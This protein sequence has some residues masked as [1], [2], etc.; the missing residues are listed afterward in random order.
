MREELIDR[1]KL[2]TFGH[3]LRKHI[4]PSGELSEG[5]LCARLR[6]PNS[7]FMIII[8]RYP[9]P[10]SCKHLGRVLFANQPFIAVY[11]VLSFGDLHTERQPAANFQH[12][13]LA[14][15]YTANDLK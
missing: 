15:I 12:P 5:A 8:S 1:L 9:C 7:T 13:D 11:P 2:D 4:S 6:E 14:V 3:C 10:Q